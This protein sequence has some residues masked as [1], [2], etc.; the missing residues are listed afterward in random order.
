MNR[1]DLERAQGEKK[2]EFEVPKA[3]AERYDKEL[4]LL[5][6]KAKTIFAEIDSTNP[7]DIDFCNSI[8]DKINELIEVLSKD[9]KIDLPYLRKLNLTDEEGNA[10]TEV[11]SFV[12]GSLVIDGEKKEMLNRRIVKA[13]NEKEAILKY[14]KVV[15]D[16]STT[17]TCFGEYDTSENYSLNIENTEEIE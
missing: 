1:E 12:I 2:V 3:I 7:D 16:G 9:Q 5:L 6:T 13:R 10:L 14:K 17:V 15:D 8:V 4:T 11:K